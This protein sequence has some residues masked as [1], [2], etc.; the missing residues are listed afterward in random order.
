MPAKT[1]TQRI[2]LLQQLCDCRWQAMLELADEA[3]ERGDAVTASGWRWLA[4]RRRWP[5]YSAKHYRWTMVGRYDREDF[6]PAILLRNLYPKRS[7]SLSRLL[8][9]TAEEVG[10]LLAEGELKG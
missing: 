4:E 8:E 10:K 5:R 9:G 6:I 3:E 7:V 1:E 2:R